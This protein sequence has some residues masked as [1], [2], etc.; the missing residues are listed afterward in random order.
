M[1][2][3]LYGIDIKDAE[4]KLDAV[5]CS[6]DYIAN[7]IAICSIQSYYPTLNHSLLGRGKSTR[8]VTPSGQVCITTAVARKSLSLWAKSSNGPADI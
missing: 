1:N 8:F 6:S 3:A 5:V 2:F 4:K 7:L